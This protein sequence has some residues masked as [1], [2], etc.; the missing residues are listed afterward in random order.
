MIPE[1][2]TVANSIA[3][4]TPSATARFASEK[5]MRALNRSTERYCHDW[6]LFLVRG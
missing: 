5:V 4:P 2:T 1:P 6:A 3:V